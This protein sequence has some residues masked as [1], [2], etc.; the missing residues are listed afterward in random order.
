MKPERRQEIERLYNLVPELEPGRREA[1][2]K[3]ACA[4]GLYRLA[5]AT[6]R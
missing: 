3:V 6:K 2:I 5:F 1:F 4:G